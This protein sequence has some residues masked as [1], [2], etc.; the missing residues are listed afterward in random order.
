MA[1]HPAYSRVSYR[2]WLGVQRGVAALMLVLLSPMFAVLFLLV[3]L[4]SRGPFLYRQQ[5]PGAEG[6]PFAIWKI[7]T[8]AV[9]SDRNTANGLAV[10]RN[11]SEVTP[12]GRILRELKIDEL[13][14]MW[15]IVRGD[16]EF[17]GPRPIAQNLF[18][19]LIAELPRFEIRNIVRPGLTNIGQVCIFQNEPTE[20][21]LDDWSI[22]LEGELHY[23]KHKSISYDMILIGLTALF[24]FRKTLRKLTD[25]AF[26]LLR[27]LVGLTARP[28]VDNSLTPT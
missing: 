14:Q 21:V 17:V 16:M 18:D 2:A 15:N 7:R 27:R 28:A 1:M 20:T 11:S 12:I 25:G 13:P 5:R 10:D 4:T 19:K 26:G 8:M 24:V 9:G 23:L 6:R 3:K 22:R